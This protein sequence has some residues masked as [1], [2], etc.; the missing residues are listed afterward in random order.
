MKGNIKI[1]FIGLLVGLLSSCVTSRKVNYMQEPDK[2]IPHYADTLSFEDYTLRIGDRLYIYVYS[3]NEEIMKMYNSGGTNAS[4]MRQ[5]MGQ[6][7]TYGS[8]D[9]YTYLVDQEGNIDFPT[10]GKIY[11]RGLTTREVKKKLEEEL[12]TLLSELPGGFSMVSVEVNIVNRSFSIIGAQSGRYAINKE[13]MT[14]FEALAMAGDLG[15]FNSR[16]EIKLVRE[17][18]GVT[19]IKTFDARSKDI[20][21]SEYYYVEPNDI[22]YIRQIPG[23]SFGINSAATAVGVTATTI[24]FGIFVYSVVQ[25]VIRLSTPKAAATTPQN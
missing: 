18:N 25:T 17:K 4:Q 10:I 6:G 16:K 7:S 13:K 24:S 15:E 1:L 3:L 20:I 19:T 5:Q 21:N 11:V 2:Y 23:Y 9:L 22:I 8:Y 12:G 14:I